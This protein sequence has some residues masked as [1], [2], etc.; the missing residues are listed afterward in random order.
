MLQREDFNNDK[1]DAGDIG[2]VHT[3]TAVYKMTVV[4]A[5]SLARPKVDPLCYGKKKKKENDH[6]TNG[7]EYT[8]EEEYRF[9]KIGYK[10]PSED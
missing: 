6:T 4:S 5:D 2:A 3:V 10:L 8:F 1:V 7:G 9:L